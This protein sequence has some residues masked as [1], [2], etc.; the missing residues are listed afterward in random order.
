MAFVPPVMDKAARGDGVDSGAPPGWN[1]DGGWLLT[2]LVAGASATEWTARL[3]MTPAQLLT[4]P[5]AGAAAI[6][7]RAGWRLAVA[8]QAAAGAATERDGRSAAGQNG[9]DAADAE[10][11]DWAAALLDADRQFVNRPPSVW[12]PDATLAGLLPADARAAR[13]AALLDAVG[14]DAR[15][16][17]AQR[18]MAELACHPV[19]WPA[20]LADA[21][22]GALGR[23]AGRPL[24]TEL[25][26][27]LLGAAGRAMPAS[28]AR[29]Y[30]AELTRLAVATPEAMP[31][32][33]AMR[34]AAET[35]TL[36]RAFLAELPRHHPMTPPNEGENVDR[37]R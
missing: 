20:A 8:R 27:A 13:T 15:P 23:A 32:M 16:P 28:G 29:D 12:V 3:R 37:H 22:L 33:P 18:V 11:A 19:P 25:T 9:P 5:V 10:L 30:A 31:W 1:D 34:A 2:Q 6:D 4:L 24:L 17:Q 21:A 35:I 36:R 14:Q 26:Q 7:V